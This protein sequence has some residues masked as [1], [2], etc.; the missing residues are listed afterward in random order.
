MTMDDLTAKKEERVFGTEAI[1]Q[2]SSS[3]KDRETL[4]KETAEEVA[5]KISPQFEKLVLRRKGYEELL[6]L[7]NEANSAS[8]RDSLVSIMTELSLIEN[9]SEEARALQSHAIIA[10]KKIMSDSEESRLTTTETSKSKIQADL[11]ELSRKKKLDLLEAKARKLEDL[12]ASAQ[13]SSEEARLDLYS[14]ESWSG[15]GYSIETV[16]DAEKSLSAI[17]NVPLHTYLLRDDSK[18]DVM[19]HSNFNQRRTR[20]HVGVIDSEGASTWLPESDDSGSIDASTVFAYNLKALSQL[21]LEIDSLTVTVEA[22][23]SSPRK[24]NATLRLEGVAEIISPKEEEL[25]G[26]EFDVSQSESS[27]KWK[28]SAQL[29]AETSALES[30]ASLAEMDLLTNTFKSNIKMVISQTKHYSRLSLL[31][32]TDISTARSVEAAKVIENQRE[33]DILRAEAELDVTLNEIATIGKII[34]MKNDTLRELLRLKE[35]SL[36]EAERARARIL[37]E[38]EIERETESAS[39]QRIR[40]IGEEATKATIEIIKVAFMNVADAIEYTF[41][42]S[43]EDV[44]ERMN[45]ICSGVALARARGAPLRHVLIYGKPGTGKSA[46]AKAMGKGILGLPYALM[47]GSDLAPLGKH[48]P[49]EL[50]K[51]LTWAQGQKRGA[52]LIIDEAEAALGRRLRASG[53]MGSESASGQDSTSEG[54]GHARDALNVLLSM[55]GSASCELMLVLT[56]SNP[57]ALDEA[58]LDRMDE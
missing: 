18:G 47:S 58:V 19:V 44:E 26:D 51:L 11:E 40:V 49:D 33:T 41:K 13:M 2:S 57:K 20:R 9:A 21:A 14:L 31:D 23:I 37:S 32:E 10:T 36:G 45:R 7:L 17:G 15:A 30:E 55:T 35:A 5:M 42:T 27:Y 52:L 16:L 1:I 46:V 56:T 28:S 53:G 8:R 39:I 34:S 3:T 12:L 6:V 29:A 25:T 38:A 22:L 4:V 50:R 24:H 48:G 54:E 43:Q